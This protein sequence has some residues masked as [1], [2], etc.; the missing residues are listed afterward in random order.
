MSRRKVEMILELVD[1]ATR[2]ARRFIALQQRMGK[3]VDLANRMA[4]RSAR[5]A[6]RA[7]NIYKRAVG[8]LSRAQD[9]LQRGIRRSN[10]LI[11]RQV[12]QMRNATG[13]MR[14]GVMGM[15]RAALLAGGMF[16]AYA[17]TVSLAASSFLGPARQFENFGVQLESIEGS[18]AK[19]QAAM[20]WIEDFATRTPLELHQV[21][22]SFQQMRTFGMDPT[23]GSM[24]AL[25]DTMAASGKGAEQLQGLVLALGKSWTKGK[26]QGEEI[27][28]L[29]ER[30]VPVWDMLAQKTGKNVDQLQKMSSAGKLGRKE[31]QL[32][33]D[34]MAEK[35]AGASDKMS[36]TWDGIISNLM[37]KWTSFQ[38]LVMSFGVFDWMKS[39]LRGFL[40]LLDE[41]KE[42]GELE[43]WAKTIAENLLIGLNA[44]WDFGVAAVRF[45]QQLYPWIER[46]ADALGGWRNL[47][48]AVLA[49]PFRGVILGA[50]F[51]LVQFA[52]GALWAM[53][54]L[55]GIGFGSAA[56]GAMWLGKALLGLANPINWVKG[57][58]VALRVALISTGIG[59]LVVGLAMAG[60]WIYNNWSGLKSFFKGFGE[61]FMKSLGPA[62]PLAE[63]VIRVVRRLWEWIGR[64]TGPLDASAE[65]WAEWGRAAGRWVGESLAAVQRFFDR[66]K[67]WF[68]GDQSYS[69]SSLITPLTWTAA[70]I[71]VLTI[72]WFRK[73]AVGGTRLGLKLLFAPLIWSA[74]LLPRLWPSRLLKFATGGA[75]LSLAALIKPLKWTTSFIG[76]V[77]WLKLA[78]G[79][80][81]FGLRNLIKPLVWSAKLLGGPIGWALLLGE[82]AWH[83][84]IK[85]LD[86][87]QFEWLNFEWSDIL[88][89]WTWDWIPSFDLASK[90]FVSKVPSGSSSD[91]A[92]V[93]RAVTRGQSL[94]YGQKVTPIAGARARGGPVGAGLPYLVGENGPEIHYSSHGG[95][96][97]HN[98]ALE[99]MTSLTRQASQSHRI[100][101]HIS[102]AAGH[103]V[104]LGTSNGAAT[105]HKYLNERNSGQS[106]GNGPI[107]V[108]MTFNGTV[109]RQALPDIQAMKEELLE[110]L[111]DLLEDN[112]RAAIRREHN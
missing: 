81:K 8:G 82:L 41:M 61:A 68:S 19:G 55:A 66:I 9:A 25:V 104:D 18:A 58:F 78:G 89:T 84:I 99:R 49:I 51:S 111:Q 6:S 98:R 35:N 32:L 102:S 75:K 33:I 26:L 38:R 62:R 56:S 100:A 13:M 29:M 23:N 54:A 14:G 16:T 39:K 107:S 12:T 74:K 109:D 15:G 10:A 70:L 59:A 110:Q 1:R 50:A 108:N 7:T 4:T 53:K 57:A 64:L 17:G 63:G 69:L 2:P 48:L 37:D 72:R 79:G 96:I 87:S 31:I 3:A 71:P 106:S 92:E 20:A 46:A 42:S 80:L 43:I 85:R 86:W 67:G 65:K 73:L 28:M 40:D 76:K 44:I 77:P 22:E 112:G 11:R 97:A 36:K 101:A 90:L 5:S 83:L 30:G 52:G 94:G 60:V 93:K 21:V 24:L 91:P 95:Y 105:G 47:A 27:M 88:P 34:A 103:E 45:W